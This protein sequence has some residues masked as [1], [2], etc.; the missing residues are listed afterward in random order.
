ML[1]SLGDSLF[2]S[3]RSTEQEWRAAGT[4]DGNP[5][6]RAKAVRHGLQQLGPY[7]SHP[8]AG[9]NGPPTQTGLYLSFPLDPRQAAPSQSS[10]QIPRETWTTLQGVHRTEAILKEPIGRCPDFIYIHS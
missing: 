6:P 1:W 8:P 5:E 9:M 2:T 3:R 7:C 10:L 4:E